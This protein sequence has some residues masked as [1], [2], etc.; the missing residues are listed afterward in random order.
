MCG[1]MHTDEWLHC[2]G[3]AVFSHIPCLA[4][5]SLLIHRSHIHMQDMNK[6][7]RNMSDISMPRNISRTPTSFKPP[8]QAPWLSKLQVLDIGDNELH[9][10]APLPALTHLI[11]NLEGS[12]GPLLPYM[13][14]ALKQLIVTGS[15]R[16]DG[17][18]FAHLHEFQVGSFEAINNGIG[19]AWVC[20][21]VSGCRAVQSQL[22]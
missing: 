4:S 17:A 20:S 18:N 21:E 9:Q 8:P 16:E 7:G 10:T 19:E 15:F 14:P 1:I 6:P 5:C 12:E 13:Y 11:C 22:H 2:Q 3:I